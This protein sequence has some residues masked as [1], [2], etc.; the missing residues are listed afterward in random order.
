MYEK[1][2]SF[3][4]PQ[5]C[6]CFSTSFLLGFATRIWSWSFWYYLSN[7]GVWMWGR[8]RKWRWRT[9]EKKMWETGRFHKHADPLSILAPAPM[10]LSILL[11]CVYCHLMYCAFYIIPIILLYQNVCSIKA[12]NFLNITTVS[13]APGTVLRTYLMNIFGMNGV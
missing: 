4:S 10:A 13:P 7:F 6:F 1:I 11:I 2:L 5:I 8:A 3:Y 9:D 12:G